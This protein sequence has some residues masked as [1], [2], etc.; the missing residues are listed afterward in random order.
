MHGEMTVGSGGLGFDSAVLLLEDIDIAI[1]MSI[2]LSAY[3]ED[4]SAW[5]KSQVVTTAIC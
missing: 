5:N 4:L 1:V 2:A 3:L